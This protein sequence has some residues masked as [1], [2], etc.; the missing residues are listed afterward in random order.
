MLTAETV[1]SRRSKTK[2]NL[3]TNQA[4]IIFAN[5][6][7][8]GS[9]KFNQDSNFLY[10]TGLNIPEGILFLFK[11]EKTV[12]EMLFIQR[13][14]PE[15][16]VWDGKKMSSE[17]AKNFSGIETVMY[18]EDFY[19]QMMMFLPS[20]RKIWSNIGIPNPMRPLSFPMFKL[21]PLRKIYPHIP[22]ENLNSIMR[23]LRNIKAEWELKQ[24]QKAID[25]TALS[26]AE[27]MKQARSGMMEYELEAMIQYQ[28]RLQGAKNWGFAP[29][30]ATGV[31]AATLHYIQNNT[32]INEGEVVLM[33]VGATWENY[34]ADITRCFPVSGSFSPRQKDVYL[35]VLEI[36][37]E[38]I[39]LIKPGIGLPELNNK[40][41]ELMGSALIGLG[42][43]DDA[44][45]VQKYYMHSISHHLGMDTHDVGLRDSILEAGNVITVEPGIYI[46]EE[47]LGIRIEDDILVTAKGAKVLSKDI[48]KE[49]TEIE[50][51][52]QAALK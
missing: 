37:K 17:E 4:V 40:T 8:Q 48:P 33:D 32:K 20:I 11:N 18:L 39:S 43:I 24:I 41:N 15:R 2:E 10:L 35:A 30:L 52:R 19:P 26:I 44:K 34:S 28:L 46:P 51:I 13:G 42:L 22:V 36:Q 27:V 38:I 6:E 31:N 23:P 29:I 12:S 9:E 16:E 14:I 3:E 47:N 5:P 25:I 49:I 50:K 7:A 21:E 45:D 1:S